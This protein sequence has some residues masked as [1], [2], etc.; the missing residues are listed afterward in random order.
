MSQCAH[1]I[2]ARGAGCHRADGPAPF[3]DHKGF[4]WMA[5]GERFR[6]RFV[7]ERTLA[8]PLSWLGPYLATQVW[9][10]LRKHHARGKVPA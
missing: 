8:S 3:H 10:V 1:R 4:N 7:L 5:L 6:R 2:H 9:F